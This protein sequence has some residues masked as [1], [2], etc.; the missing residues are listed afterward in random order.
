MG[1]NKYLDHVPEI[2]LILVV[3]VLVLGVHDVMHGDEVLVLRQDPRTRPAE[4]LHVPAHAQHEADVH[5]ERTD[6]RARLAV[7]SKDAEVALL[8]ELEEFV[9]VDG[10]HAE[11]PLHRRDQRR[12]LEERARQRLQGADERP[13]AFDGIVQ[14]H[15][16]NV[17]LAG[18][19]LGLDEA[20]G[21]VDTHDQTPRH[22][23][24]QSARV[25]RLLHTEN[26]TDP[27]DHLVRRWVRRL[28]E[29]DASVLEV[30]EERALEGR[31]A[32]WDRAVVPGAHV[33]LVVVLEQQRPL[34]RVEWWRRLRGLDEEVGGGLCLCRGAGLALV[35][36]WRLLLLGL[37]GGA[38]PGLRA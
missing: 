14:P 19:L 12:P 33:E 10:A 31:V 5:T 34:R 16:R 38:H 30:L 29:I 26:P 15:D 37:L 17:L 27:G 11:L 36:L 32:R 20:G 18:A 6:I 35:L 13:F 2:A 7:D 28:V 3:V 9:G 1:E 24:V 4:L 22:L 8:V 21:A 23:R 25:A